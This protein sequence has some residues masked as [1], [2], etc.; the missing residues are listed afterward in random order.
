MGKGE[1][2]IE[3]SRWDMEQYKDAP[4]GCF[5]RYQSGIF[6]GPKCQRRNAPGDEEEEEAMISFEWV[7][8]FTQTKVTYSLIYQCIRMWMCQI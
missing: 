8:D 1:G 5:G 2:I 6:A 4:H 3:E 7:D